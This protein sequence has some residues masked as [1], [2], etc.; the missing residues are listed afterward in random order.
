MAVDVD[1]AVGERDG[2]VRQADDTL[3]EVGDGWPRAVLERRSREDDDVRP[4]NAVEV[5]GQL[6]HHDPV[7]D[8]QGRLHGARWN[9]VG[10][11]DEGTKDDGH[12]DRHDHDAD[13]LHDPTVRPPALFHVAAPARRRGRRVGRLV[14]D[15][16]CDRSITWRPQ[17][18]V[19]RPAASMCSMVTAVVF[20]FYGTLA[21][22]A[23]TNA[24]DYSAVFAA[25]GYTLDPVVL[26]DYF[27]RYDGMEHTEHSL[28]ED[29]YEAWVRER[30]R[31]LT[32]SCG[33]KGTDVEA[34]VDGL[35]QTDRGQ[36]VAYPEAAATLSSFARGGNRRW[37]LLEIGAGSSTPSWAM[38]NFSI[39]STQASRR[40]VRA[41]AKPHPRAS[42]PAHSRRSA[43]H[44]PTCS[45]SGTPG[46]PTCVARVAA[47]WP[48][49]TSGARRNASGA[50]APPLEPGDRRI[51]DLSG[52]LGI[53]E[54]DGGSAPDGVPFERSS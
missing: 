54:I 5:V 22:W 51:E 14:V 40:L 1:L 15:V 42:T 50:V 9:G 17:C 46:G 29:A 52:V 18:H 3:D 7:P 28:S 33:V 45:S 34:V 24:S 44:R 27:H 31:D 6:V 8:L 49:R 10:G 39:S 26:G 43:S 21:R 38:S 48:P 20:D 37:R 4:A 2:L 35:R 47:A 32:A 16:H 13:E 36:M 41:R 53:L 12:D 30:L 11:D 23:D 25:F 19:S